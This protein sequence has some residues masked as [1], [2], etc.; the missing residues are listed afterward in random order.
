[1]SKLNVLCI[2]LCY[3]RCKCSRM[4]LSQLAFI[5]C[6]CCCRCKCAKNENNTCLNRVAQQPLQLKLQVFKTVNRGW[7]IRCLND[8][9]QGGFICIYAGRL[10]TEQGA[11]EV[12]PCLTAAIPLQAWTGPEG[13]RRLRLPDFKTIGI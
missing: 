7:G 3:C 1:M 6:F 10:L 9:P 2:C 11:N 8:I 12:T 5:I 13:S 4:C